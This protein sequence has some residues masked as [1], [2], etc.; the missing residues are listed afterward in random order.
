MDIARELARLLARHQ[1]DALSV[2]VLIPD[3]E[4]ELNWHSFLGHHDFWRFR[5]DQFTICGKRG[6]TPL[7]ERQP[8]FGVARL[9]AVWRELERANPE[10]ICGRSLLERRYRWRKGNPSPKTNLR[11]DLEGGGGPS[12]EFLA[13]WDE[14]RNGTAW[15]YGCVLHDSAVLE[16]YF[17]SSFRTYLKSKV[18]VL[19]TGEHSSAVFPRLDW[20]SP[21]P[22]GR[23]E[24]VALE[25]A[26]ARAMTH[27]FGVGMEV[28]R[29]LF[30]DWLLSLWHED[31]SVMFD[32]YKHDD[33]AVK[34]GC[35]HGWYCDRR[36]FL[37]MCR[38]YRPDLPPRVIN[39][40]IWIHQN[41]QT[42]DCLA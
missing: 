40:C 35:K 18:G 14:F 7:R 6:F 41:R 24:T 21:V 25:E 23:G 30:C 4:E 36:T 13:V 28:A 3:T 33:N 10:G 1:A 22:D 26:L 34:F 39:E 2:G 5:G 32:S 15:A 29:Y 8:P 27:D 37:D 42:C 38:R 11:A 17:A 12:G 20:R 9:A 19:A 31:R 16:E